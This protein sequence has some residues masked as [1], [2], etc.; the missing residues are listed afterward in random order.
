MID[1]LRERQEGYMLSMPDSASVT[2]SCAISHAAC[3][4]EQGFSLTWA[5]HPTAHRLRKEMKQNLSSSPQLLWDRTFRFRSI[6]IR[7]P[8]PHALVPLDNGHAE[9]GLGESI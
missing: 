8:I 9:A 4:L 7:M 2:A 5:T 1:V 3:E 6:E